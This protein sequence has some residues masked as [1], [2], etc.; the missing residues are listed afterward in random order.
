MSSLFKKVPRVA[1]ST[2][3]GSLI[4]VVVLVALPAYSADD[5]PLTLEQAQSLAL[6]RS[7]L[8]AAQDFSLQAA[9]EMALAAGQLPDPVLK[10]GIDNLPVT[11]ADRYSLTD[12]GMTMRRVALMQELTGA[13]KRTARSDLAERE[14]DK[15]RA[16]K[17]AAIAAIERDTALAWLD[18]HYAQQMATV[19]VEQLAQGRLEIAAADSA[20]RASRGSLADIFSARSSLV[21]MQDRADEIRQR[22][23]NARTS[24]SRWVG[25]LAN[26]VLADPPLMTDIHLDAQHLQSQLEQHPQIALLDQQVSIARAEARLAQAN[27]RADWSVELAYQQRGAPNANM[28]SVELSIP[29][30]WDKKNRQDRE[31]FAKQAK[32]DQA[33]AE[34]DEQLR[35]HVSEMQSMIFEWQNNR[36]RLDRYES[37]LLPL[38]AQRTAALVSAYRSGKA[39]LADLLLARRN[40]I[41]V[42]LQSLQLQSETARLWAQLEFLSPALNRKQP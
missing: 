42:H 17:A 16:E 30:Q 15:T 8:L 20:Y 13:D 39:S 7:R 3:A 21:L 25:P 4:V 24:L 14:A 40:E 12:D 37:E 27:Q 28:I 1:L 23:N 6:S 19:I 11:G 32:V 33:S 36:A 5:T 34:R 26:A 22:I 35:V 18:S 10:M 41:D 38:A 9:R 2:L 31:L 29:L